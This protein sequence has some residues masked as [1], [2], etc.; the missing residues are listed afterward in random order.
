MFEALMP[1]AM[2]RRQSARYRRF[3]AVAYVR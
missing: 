3:S 1:S 2:P